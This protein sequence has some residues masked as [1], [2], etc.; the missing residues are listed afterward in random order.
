MLFSAEEIREWRREYHPCQNGVHIFH[1]DCGNHGGLTIKNFPGASLDL[2]RQL[3]TA[4]DG[5]DWDLLADL[6]INGDLIDN[7]AIRRQDLAVIER[8]LAA[9]NPNAE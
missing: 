4:G 5:D 3:S 6:H 2:F 9:E 8:A 7:V 1:P